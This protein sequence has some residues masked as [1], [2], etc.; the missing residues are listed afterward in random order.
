MKAIDNSWFITNEEYKANLD[1]MYNEVSK[2]HRHIRPYYFTDH[3]ITH[4]ERIMHHLTK[5]FPFIF[6][7]G[8]EEHILSDVEKFI[9]FSAILLH[10][11]GIALIDNEKIKQLSAKYPDTLN[12]PIDDKDIDDIFIR[13]NHH[14]ISKLWILEESSNALGDERIELRKAYI[15]NKILAKYVANVCESHGID[16]EKSPVHI[17]TTAY[18]YEKIRMGLLCTLLSLG[19]ALDCDQ[20]RIDYDVLKTSDISDDSRVHWMKHYYVDG[21]ILTSNLIEIYYSFPDNGNDK[22]NN[23]YKDYFVQ[24]TKYWIE[25]CFSIRKDFIFPLNAIC[26]VVDIVEFTQDKD[27]LKPDELKLVKEEYLKELTE[28]EIQLND[29]VSFLNS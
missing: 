9:L 14:L 3:T 29:M 20:S 13:K 22:L 18:G 8:D 1:L 27:F 26:R 7:N 25:K 5:L 28:K 12:L 11:I 23:L 21:I 2:I 16:F 24:K 17:K 15:G 10:D 4:S 6:I 19:D